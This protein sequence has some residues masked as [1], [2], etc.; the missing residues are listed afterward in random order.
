[1]FVIALV[2]LP[3]LIEVPARPDKVMAAWHGQI[4]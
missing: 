2:C 4:G 3:L 1:V